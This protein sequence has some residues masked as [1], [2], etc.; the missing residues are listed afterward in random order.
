MPYA[1]T[2][3]SNRTRLLQCV[4]RI[5]GRE[6]VVHHNWRTNP[7]S[8]SSAIEAAPCPGSFFSLCRSVVKASPQKS[9]TANH[10][11]AARSAC[12]RRTGLDFSDQFVESS[13]SS[14]DH[15]TPANVCE[16]R[17]RQVA[18]CIRQVID[19]HARNAVRPC[20]KE[21]CRGLADTSSR[22]QCLCRSNQL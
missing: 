1:G 8:A 21:P 6:S 2:K 17:R 9:G 5:V 16:D 15:D 3:L 10:S 13:S 12:S 4:E 19:E 22:F 20:R 7:D 11:G 18:A 14:R